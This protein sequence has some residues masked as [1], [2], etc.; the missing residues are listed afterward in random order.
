MRF[1]STFTS[2]RVEL[3]TS[4]TEAIVKGHPKMEFGR[5]DQHLTTKEKCLIQLESPLPQLDRCRI[6]KEG[7]RGMAFSEGGQ[8]TFRTG[9]SGLAL[10]GLQLRN[11]KSTNYLLASRKWIVFSQVFLQT[12]DYQELNSVI[13][14]LPHTEKS[15]HPLGK[16]R[17]HFA[18]LCIVIF[19]QTQVP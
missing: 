8:E 14:A 11:W 4:S 16:Q 2:P 19:F 17:Q 6:E 1:K 9:F 5:G 18:Q 12:P 3:Q 15:E 7:D 10:V 13:H